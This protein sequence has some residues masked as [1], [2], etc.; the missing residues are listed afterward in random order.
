M[1]E[2]KFSC[3]NCDQH[4]IAPEGYGGAQINCPSC[5]K[6]IVVPGAPVPAAAPTVLG[7]QR[8]AAPPAHAPAA[9]RPTAY[10]TAMATP[11]PAQK[12]GSGGLKTALVVSLIVIVCAALGVGGWF[13]YKKFKV[14][15][16][17][18]V[19]AKGNPATQVAAPTAA[20]AVQAL[21][22]LS[23]V[24]SA[25]TNFTSISAAGTIT[26][27]L[28][29]SNITMADVNPAAPKTSA[30]AK[31]AT[32]HPQGMPNLITNTT[33]FTM[34]SSGT[35]LYCFTGEAVSKIDRQAI[36]QTIA[37]WSSGKGKFMF[38]DSHQ[39]AAPATYMQL[40]DVNPGA[41]TA[42]QIKNVQHLFDDPANLT[43]I[44]KDLGQTDDE[45]VNGQDCYTLTAKVLGQ[46][47]KIW[48][49]KSSYLIPQWQ[50]TLGGP[51]SDEDIDDAFSLY[52]A[53][54]TNTP[55]AMLEM[56]KA[57]VKKMTPVVTK[58]RGTIASTS[59]SIELNPTLSADDF[60]YPVP[61]GVRL[62][63][64]PKVNPRN[65]APA[66]TTTEARWRNACINNLRQIDAAKNQF[67]LEN[68]KTNGD[69]VT[70]A[71]IKPYIKLD[72]DGNLPK[73]PA[74]GKYTIGKVGENPTCSIDG[75]VLP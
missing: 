5:Q 21:S 54:I 32:R 8:P 74:G 23:K 50:I 14:K 12:S 47:I 41:G 62:M 10:R 40:P 68:K 22:I 27:F 45:P 42:E 63:P 60:N 69:T 13:G 59:K 71:D 61:A 66:A 70:E 72:A 30:A 49:D 51:I 56:I 52:S 39:K 19:A 33:E 24:H 34:K 28:N 44:I 43:K 55:P 4:I 35:N 6:L 2:F 26:V 36:T 15:H 20:E 38:M 11:P 7:I 46:K 48:V 73:C 1:S 17:A 67:A 75:H 57:Q 31:S 37:Y 64:A 65:T 16:D 53:A 29:L 58:I 25:Y 3:P 18:A 9:P